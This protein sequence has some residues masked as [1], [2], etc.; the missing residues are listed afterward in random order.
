M[1]ISFIDGVVCIILVEN[2]NKGHGTDREIEVS[3]RSEPKLIP[4]DQDPVIHFSDENP[5]INNSEIYFDQ[6]FPGEKNP[7]KLTTMERKVF[8]C[9]WDSI[10]RYPFAKQKCEFSIY[11]ER[12]S[13]EQT[14]L[15][16]KKLYTKPLY[17]V[18]QEK[19][20]LISISS[21]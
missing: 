11:I 19:I 13:N 20:H 15:V 10:N 6:V 3:R 4:S 9:K 8:L 16:P 14:N 21:N 1:Y 7:L 2:E 18:G 12:S 17:Q 5:G